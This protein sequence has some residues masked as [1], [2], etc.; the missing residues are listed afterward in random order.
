M[1]VIAFDFGLRRIGV[2]AGNSI[3]GKATPLT[4]L[5][6]KQGKPQWHQVQELIQQWQPNTL[7]VG[8]PL[9]MDGSESEFCTKV[10]RFANRLQQQTHLEVL[11]FDERLSSV[12]ARQL[13]ADTK[14]HSEPIDALV[15]S[16]ILESWFGHQQSKHQ[17]N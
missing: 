3:T 1:I 9:N 12:E 6:A 11:L 17:N 14:N 8:W 4:I 2:A 10:K 7:L 5:A 15:A 16:L 13:V